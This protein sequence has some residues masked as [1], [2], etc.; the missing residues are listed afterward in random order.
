M[1][2]PAV[3]A[4]RRPASLKLGG[5]GVTRQARK[6]LQSRKKLKTACVF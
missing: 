3:Y 6:S 5:V 4:S 2:S 1:T